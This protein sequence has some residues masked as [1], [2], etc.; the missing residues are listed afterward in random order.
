MKKMNN[1]CESEK[2]VDM[3]LNEDLNFLDG[4]LL[5]GEILLEKN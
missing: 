1:L 3:A 5:K 2:F 4:I